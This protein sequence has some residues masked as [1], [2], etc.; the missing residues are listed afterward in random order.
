MAPTLSFFPCSEGQCSMERWQEL[1]MH[2]TLQDVFAITITIDSNDNGSQC[3]LALAAE[4]G[5]EPVLS[6]FSSSGQRAQHVLCTQRSSALKAGKSQ[7]AAPPTSA[8][9]RLAVTSPDASIC[10]HL[11]L[12]SQPVPSRGIVWRSPLQPPTPLLRPPVSPGPGVCRVK[13]RG[14]WAATHTTPDAGQG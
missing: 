11:S 6:G 7:R 10:L 13:S 14:L 8:A 12:Q 5:L 4:L 2:D 3:L 9:P 1:G